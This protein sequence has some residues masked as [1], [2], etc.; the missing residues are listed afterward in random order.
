MN[1][2]DVRVWMQIITGLFLFGLFIIG[3]W[4]YFR[5]TADYY[6]LYIFGIN[7]ADLVFVIIL[8]WLFM[9]FIG[10][11]LLEMYS[12]WREETRKHNH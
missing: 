11:E 3:A 5:N 2:R 6:W 1:S 8:I 7:L 9:Y 10:S 4:I 12:N